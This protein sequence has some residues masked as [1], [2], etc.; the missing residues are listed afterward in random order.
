MFSG[1]IAE[2][3]RIT[4]VSRRGSM[5]S[6][7]VNAPKLAPELKPGDSVAVN[8]ACQT[9]VWSR[10]CLFGFDSVPETLR[11]TNLASLRVGSAVNLEPALRLG[12]RISG[13]LLTGHVDGKG[14]IRRRRTLGPR[15]IDFAIQVPKDLAHLIV[16]K[17]SVAFDGIS[18][19]VKRKSGAIVEVTVIPF[20]LENTIAGAWQVGTSVNIEV[21]LIARYLAQD[22]HKGRGWKE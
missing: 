9:V 15:N 4:K 14:M 7:T 11:R 1:I 10:G 6:F 8:G 16:E 5:V 12:D 18:F 22:S 13:H 21:D 19:T 17:G 20:T 3:G 2:V